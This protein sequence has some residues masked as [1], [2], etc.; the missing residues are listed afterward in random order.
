MPS[1]NLSIRQRRLLHF[2]AK[3]TDFVSGLDVAAYLNVTSRTVRNDVIEINDALFNSGISI[4]S[5]RGYGYSLKSDDPRTLSE[6][7]RD[8]NSFLSR[9][10]RIRYIAI[11]LCLAE[12][13]INLYDLE[14]EMFVSRTTLEHDLTALKKQCFLKSPFI[15]LIR[16]K[17]AIS[18]EQDERKIRMLMTQTITA[19]WDYSSDGSTLFK[20]DYLDRKFISRIMKRVLEFTEK[21]KFKFEDINMIVIS[22]YIAIADMRIQQGHPLLDFYPCEIL[23]VPTHES[24]K[25][26][27]ASMSDILS[28]PFS[29]EEQYELG[30][31]LSSCKM[32][33]PHDLNWD[34]V[35]KYFSL[36]LIN[37]TDKYIALINEK[38]HLD[39]SDNEDFY[40]TVLQYFRYLK[41]PSHPINSIISDSNEARVELLLELEIANCIQSMALDF[42]GR[43]IA[44]SELLYL[45]FCISGALSYM[46][47]TM[48]KL[49][50]VIMCHQNLPASWN[51]MHQ[52]RRHF[53]EYVRVA[54]L[55]PVYAK[56]TYDFSGIDLII[57]TVRKPI[58][59]MHNCDVLYISPFFSSADQ[60]A[61]AYYINNKQTS[62]FYSS[63]LPALGEL[64][65]DAFWHE[66]LDEDELFPILKRMAD[67]LI[68]H[69][70]ADDIYFT[71]LLRQ[72]SILSFAF[73]PG[74]ALVYSDVPGAKTGLS[75]ATLNHRLKWNGY[76]IRLIIMV[77][78]KPGDDSLLLKITNELFRS[79]TIFEDIMPLKTRDE[80]MNYF[81][82]FH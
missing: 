15:R 70:Y 78:T 9:D 30:I 43:Y 34:T 80:L 69:G 27:L 18:F 20:Y 53:N 65:Q 46:Y 6:L 37:F 21:N 52:I 59:K 41:M 11:Q 60:D 56:D 67:D 19:S 4:H 31:M 45:A 1:Y 76:K 36:E 42:F 12:E 40:I 58:S 33:D 38:Y 10:E 81:L 50:A 24:A 29:P 44:H 71:H 26:L 25:T 3:Q 68:Q 77:C 13:P 48:P 54:T 51:L 2:L 74:I 49:Q 66:Q 73:Q 32:L 75:I 82:G 16:H 62:Y 47:R 79:P 28:V 55:L 39:F 14:D 8:T 35:P 63:S 72:E 64:M 5:K 17:N 61:L 23:D 57:M 7:T 22:L